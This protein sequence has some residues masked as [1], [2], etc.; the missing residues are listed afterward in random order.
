VET[1]KPV[2]SFSS[3]KT[4]IQC[5]K[6]YY[7]VK[8]KKDYEENFT[9]E[10]I[11]YGNEFHKAAELYMK[12]EVEELD[13]RFDFAKDA[14]LKLKNTSGEKL[15]EHKMGLT[16]NLEPCGFYDSN[17]WYRGIADLIILDKEKGVAKV[18][19]Y[20]TGKNTKYAD[21]GQLELMALCV[22][23]HFP[24]IKIVKG[25]LLFV[26]CPAVISES[27]TIE[28]KTELW[29]KWMQEYGTLLKAFETDVWNPRPTG[30]CRAHC[31]VLECPHNGRR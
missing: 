11:L 9:T 4:F 14:L 3:I 7:H 1:K 24:D 19:D 27:Y 6:K 28:N 13:P 15:C 22:F 26:V 29:R 25:G 23:A 21:R 30:L 20:K 31:V 10:A 12:G 16:S 5:P 17:V 8:V 2:W 18:L